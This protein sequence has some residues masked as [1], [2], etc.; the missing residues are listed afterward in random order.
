MRKRLVDRTLRKFFELELTGDGQDY[1]KDFAI[2][3]AHF[4]TES[5]IN[6]FGVSKCCGVRGSLQAKCR[7]VGPQRV[8]RL[9]LGEEAE[10]VG[11]AD[12]HQAGVTGLGAEL[13]SFV[14]PAPWV[15]PASY[16]AGRSFEPTPRT[17]SSD[18]S[19]KR[20]VTWPT[21]RLTRSGRPGITNFLEN[22]GTLEAAH[23]SPATPTAGRQS[24]TTATVRR[25]FWRT[26]KGCG[27][28]ISPNNGS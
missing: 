16:R 20:E 4:R 6:A 23:E 24:F 3:G 11:K 19:N 18:G 13:G 17:C 7:G 14:L 2:K 25:Y 15:E 5:V 28:K 22:D 12:A 26:W 27:I 21:I 1:C 9:G 10:E 8:G